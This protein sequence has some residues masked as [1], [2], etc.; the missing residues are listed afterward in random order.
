LRHRRH[1]F[2]DGVLLAPVNEIGGRRSIE[3]ETEMGRL[4]P[5][6]H[7]RVGIF[8]GQGTQQHGVNHAEDRAVRANS[9][10][11][12]EHC[13]EGKARVPHQHAKAVA[14][15]LPQIS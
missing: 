14:Q 9:E 4:F 1:A 10:G 13:D 3:R 6:H 11:E 12:R 8:V 15:V 7:Q 2:E 5:H